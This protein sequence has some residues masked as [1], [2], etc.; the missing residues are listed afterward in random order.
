MNFYGSNCRSHHKS[1]KYI[2]VYIIWSLCWPFGT[3]WVW[4][5]GGRMPG[6]GFAS[7]GLTQSCCCRLWEAPRTSLEFERVNHW[8]TKAVLWG[9]DA[10]LP[11]LVLWPC[12]RP[13][14]AVVALA[15]QVEAVLSGGLLVHWVV[16]VHAVHWSLAEVPV[17]E[18]C[19]RWRH[20]EHAEGRQNGCHGHVAFLAVTITHYLMGRGLLHLRQHGAAELLCSLQRHGFSVALQYTHNTKNT[21]K[22][23][24]THG[25]TREPL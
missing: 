7:L 21:D 17:D 14:G 19:Q 8:L 12:R 4:V 10:V 9:S 11:V 20:A 2:F 16:K 15:G 23:V 22:Q 5:R 6:K 13:P 3:R 18:V 24:H 1:L 25:P